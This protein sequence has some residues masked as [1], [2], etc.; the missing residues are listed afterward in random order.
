MNVEP[1]LAY[2]SD[3]ERRKQLAVDTESSPDYLWQIA[4]GRRKASHLLSKRIEAA[5]AGAVT[6]CHLRADIFGTAP[7]S[8]EEAA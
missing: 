3:I 2:I 6:R 8:R 1:L 4:T 5:T 7:A